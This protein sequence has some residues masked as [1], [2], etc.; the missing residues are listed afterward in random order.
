M[1][2]EIGDIKQKLGIDFE[3]QDYIEA[4][5]RHWSRF[6]LY[7]RKHLAEERAANEAAGLWAPL[8]PWQEAEEEET[9]AQA[10]DLLGKDTPKQCE[11]DQETIEAFHLNKYGH[12]KYLMNLPAAGR[13]KPEILAHHKRWRRRRLTEFT[14]RRDERRDAREHLIAVLG[15]P[16]RLHPPLGGCPFASDP[17]YTPEFPNGERAPQFDHLFPFVD[18]LQYDGTSEVMYPDFD[19][20]EALSQEDRLSETIGYDDL[21]EKMTKLRCK[22]RRRDLR[23]QLTWFPIDPCVPGLMEF[24]CPMQNIAVDEYSAGAGNE[25]MVP[26]QALLPKELR[27]DGCPV[28]AV[29]N[30]LCRLRPRFWNGTEIYPNG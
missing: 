23:G 14:R 4:V 17:C 5:L 30:R 1:R 21:L 8:A 16:V 28:T 7:S 27:P 13:T 20:N 9:F 10:R 6:L 24:L 11:T 29:N 22:W 12:K 25:K 18:F 19:E 2:K 3:R 26:C 15:S